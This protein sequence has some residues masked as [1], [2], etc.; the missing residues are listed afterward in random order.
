MRAVP[1]KRFTTL[2]M[3]VCLVVSGTLCSSA[4]AR[5]V[6]QRSGT[7]AWLLTVFFLD[8]KTGWVAGSNGTLLT[9]R[10]G[11]ENWNLSNKPCN[12]LIREVLFLDQSNGLLICERNRFQ[13]KT[14]DESR[15]YVLRTSDGGLT[16]HRAAIEGLD[17]EIVLTRLVFAPDGRGLLFG[18]FGALFVSSNQ[19]ES[20][21][22][23]VLPTRRVLLGG[24]VQ[25]GGNAWLVGAGSTVIRTWNAGGSWFESPV[26]SQQSRLKLNSIAF[27]DPRFGWTVG[28]RGKIFA[29]IDGGRTWITQESGVTADLHDVK[30]LDASEGWAVGDEGTVLH[31][32]NGGNTW[33]SETVETSH[34]LERV[35]VENEKRVWA[36]GYGGTILSNGG[37]S[38]RPTLNP[39][40]VD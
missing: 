32:I 1:P 16:W 8:D 40:R 11:G 22:R 12:D 17:P 2:V 14:N 38:Q 36:V 6:R 18:E 20:W 23:Q 26:S 27:A 24:A 7:F 21:K 33:V 37:D 19:G 15:S 34:P 28:D 31:T 35:F 39:A 4:Q 25:A 10:D 30:F 3:L 13:L 5:W 29:T 9:T